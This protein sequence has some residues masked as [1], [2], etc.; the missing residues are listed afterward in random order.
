[1]GSSGVFC[2]PS[3]VVEVVD[4][5]ALSVGPLADILQAGEYQPFVGRGLR[6]GIESMS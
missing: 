2:C 1:M 5:F 3:F 6:C 4:V